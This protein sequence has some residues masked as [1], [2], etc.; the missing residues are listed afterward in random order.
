M[1]YDLCHFLWKDDHHL[2]L[3]GETAVCTE[4]M[5]KQWDLIWVMFEII[6]SFP[7]CYYHIVYVVLLV[8]NGLWFVSFLTEDHPFV[9][10][11]TLR[12]AFDMWKR[13]ELIS[14]GWLWLILWQI[15]FPMKD[16][17]IICDAK[18]E[19]A[20]TM[21]FS[22]G[23]VSAE[24]IRICLIIYGRIIIHLLFWGENCCM[25]WTLI[26]AISNAKCMHI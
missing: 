12:Y 6:W 18:E 25:H 10:P 9:I 24:W 21:W 20:I 19:T 5:W 22:C 1:D 15:Q 14:I 3:Q 4:Y 16:V 13:W 23:I 11:R 17:C 2:L 26:N 8:Q 7:N